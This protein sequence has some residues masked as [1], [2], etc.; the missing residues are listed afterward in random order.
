MKGTGRCFS[1]LVAEDMIENADLLGYLNR[2]SSLLFVLGHYTVAQAGQNP[3]TFVNR[4]FAKPV[5]S[6]YRAKAG[7]QS[8]QWL[9]GFPPTRE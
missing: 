9:T 2:L 6:S 8:L 1:R 7:I 4:T 3:M 5:N